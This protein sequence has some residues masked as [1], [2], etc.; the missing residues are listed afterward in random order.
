M[1]PALV[2]TPSQNSFNPIS[3]E[4]SGVGQYKEAYIGGP[5]AFKKDVEL[6]GSSTQPA[7]RYSSICLLLDTC[8]LGLTSNRYPNYLPVWNPEKSE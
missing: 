7:A 5:K 8:I 3:K 2:E 1:A 4:V 6:R